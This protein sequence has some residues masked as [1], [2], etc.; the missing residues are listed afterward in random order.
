MQS[1]LIR[2]LPPDPCGDSCEIN[3]TH[4]SPG[5][6]IDVGTPVSL[7]DIGIDLA[8]HPLQLVQILHRRSFRGFGA[9]EE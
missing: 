9:L 7:P 4:H 2:W 3:P 8:F 1:R 5:P 6:R